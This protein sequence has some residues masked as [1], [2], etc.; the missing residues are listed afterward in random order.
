MALVAGREVLLPGIPMGEVID[1]A[2]RLLA[3]ASVADG[4]FSA[5]RGNDAFSA[6]PRCPS[7]W[8]R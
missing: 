3:Q 6:R 8:T 2:V 4:A 5:A 7:P 1:R